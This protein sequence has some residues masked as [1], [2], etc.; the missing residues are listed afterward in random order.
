MLILVF[1]TFSTFMHGGLNFGFYVR[2][3]SYGHDVCISVIKFVVLNFSELLFKAF[4]LNKSVMVSPHLDQIE[5]N[6]SVLYRINALKRYVS[7]LFLYTKLM[8]KQI[9]CV[10]IIIYSR[11]RHEIVAYLKPG[12]TSLVQF[13]IHT[14]ILIMINIKSNLLLHYKFLYSMIRVVQVYVCIQRNLLAHIARQRHNN[15]NKFCM[16]TII[17]KYEKVQQP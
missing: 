10:D 12:F 8:L 15:D 13:N 7:V 16:Q 17:T 1:Y 5:D 11:R 4:H 9:F 14:Y 3:E 6:T 2:F